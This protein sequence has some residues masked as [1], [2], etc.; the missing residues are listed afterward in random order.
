[1]ANTSFT[2]NLQVKNLDKLEDLK[3]RLGDLSIPF[4]NIVI[5][6]AKGNID[7]FALSVGQEASGAQVDDTVF[8]EPLS[9]GYMRS[10]HGGGAAR[11]TKKAKLG[12][13]HYEGAYPDWLMVRTGALRDALTNPESIFQRVEPTRVSFGTPT[14][15]DLAA[16]VAFQLSGNK[17]RQVVFL[18]RSDKLMIEQQLQAYFSFGP[19]Y[20]KILF[21]RGL[22]NV[23]NR[24]AG[25]NMQW[26]DNAASQE[27]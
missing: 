15:P 25:M 16:I 13:A 1:M 14:D 19:G 27:P 20:E 7:K 9:E 4:E 5:E 22:E 11:V 8:W 21:A 2:I 6:W 17:K 3:Q 26:S 10:K 24:T 23:Q 18:G 12:K